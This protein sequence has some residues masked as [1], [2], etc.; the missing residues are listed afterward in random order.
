M[1]DIPRDIEK[2]LVKDEIVERRF[3][4]K[5]GN[6]VFAT[7]KRLFIKK[8]NLVR[9]ID[10][11]HISSI[12]FKAQRSRVALVAGILFV[13]LSFISEQWVGDFRWILLIVGIAL[14]IVGF[15]RNEKITLAV[16]GLAEEQELSG[17][18]SKL[19][20]LFKLIREKRV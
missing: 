20:A 4:L 10:Y 6:T 19:D 15:K 9:D 7:N 3:N 1:E 5:E 12:E 17:E 14:F 2:Y 8:G 16:V 13:M 11:S 18:R